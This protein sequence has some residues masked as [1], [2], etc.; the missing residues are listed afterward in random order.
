MQA[1]RTVLLRTVAVAAALV[2]MGLAHLQ[3]RCLWPKLQ[4][5]VVLLVVMIASVVAELF[6]SRCPLLLPGR[7]PTRVD[8]SCWSRWTC[9]PVLHAAQP[10]PLTQTRICTAGETKTKKRALR[11]Q[12]MQQ[13]K[14][15]SR[16]TAARTRRT[17]GVKGRCGSKR[18]AYGL[19]ERT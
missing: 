4:T 8:R 10:R 11:C 12:E 1:R 9:A 6:G 19:F 15:A 5:A 16:C 14:E 2:R 17:D 13:S 18:K 3:Y 7:E